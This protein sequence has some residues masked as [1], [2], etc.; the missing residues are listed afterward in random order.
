MAGIAVAVA[1]LFAI[2]ASAESRACPQGG[3]T[4]ADQ[5]T[6]AAVLQTPPARLNLA[7]TVL[8]SRPDY[9]VDGFDCCGHCSCTIGANGWCSTCV[10]ALLSFIATLYLDDVSIMHDLPLE[11]G[12]APAKPPPDLRPPRASA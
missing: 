12:I 11:A 9:G 10:P 7:A 3:K 5:Q 1:W 6:V 8:L 2:L 4:S